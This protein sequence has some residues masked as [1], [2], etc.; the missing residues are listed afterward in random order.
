MVYSYEEDE[1][2]VYFMILVSHN[3]YIYQLLLLKN[4]YHKISLKIRKHKIITCGYFGR[5]A[6]NF[7]LLGSSKIFYIKPISPKVK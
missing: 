2:D 3:T 6:F 1:V 5:K 4:I 7:H